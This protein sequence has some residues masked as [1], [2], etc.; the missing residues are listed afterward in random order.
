MPDIAASV[1]PLVGASTVVVAALN[2]VPW[3]FP[4]GATASPVAHRLR[5]LDPGGA[6]EAAIPIAAVVGAVVYPACSRPEPGVTQHHWQPDRAWRSTAALRRASASSRSLRAVALLRAAGLDAEASSDIRSEVWRK[7]WHACFS[8]VSLL[9]GSALD[10]LIDD[11]SIHALFSTMMSLCRG[12]SCDPAL[13]ER[14]RRRTDRLVARARQ[15]QAIDAAGRRSRQA[16]RDR[17][18][19]GRGDRDRAHARGGH[20]RVRPGLRPRTPTGADLR[21]VSAVTEA[22]LRAHRSARTPALCLGDPRAS[23]R[24]QHTSSFASFVLNASSS[25]SDLATIGHEL[26][27]RAAPAEAHPARRKLGVRLHVPARKE[28]VGGSLVVAHQHNVAAC[29]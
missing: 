28:L 27:V 12:R 11:P 1:T 23:L 3:W 15:S 17:C 7:F 14:T 6:I 2:G 5:N 25:T 26:S 21:S 10:A 8:P 4:L 13:D 19:P 9:T 22:T 16:G 20:A 18:D 29:A 24:L